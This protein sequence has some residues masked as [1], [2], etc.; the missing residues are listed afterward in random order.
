[1]EA[2]TLSGVDRGS[3]R[4]VVDMSVR[5][6]YSVECAGVSGQIERLCMKRL[7]YWMRRS[8]VWGRGVVTSLLV[9]FRLFW[10]VSLFVG[11]AVRCVR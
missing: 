2:V 4:I 6:I 9:A 3:W 1:M 7:E 11:R 8:V 5:L 10:F